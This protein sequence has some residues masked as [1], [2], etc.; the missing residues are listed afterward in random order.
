MG[1]M[2]THGNPL[3]PMRIHGNPWKLCEID[4]PNKPS[5]SNERLAQQGNVRANHYKAL[6]L[7]ISAGTCMAEAWSSASSLKVDQP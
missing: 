2:G 7:G 3:G 1:A 4:K 6:N 5:E